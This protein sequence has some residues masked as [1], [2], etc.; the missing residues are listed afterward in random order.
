MLKR[1]LSSSR[2]Q[3][4]LDMTLSSTRGCLPEAVPAERRNV[5][6]RHALLRR[7]HGEFEEMRGLAVTP[8]QAAKL[9][10]LPGDVASRVLDQLAAASILH[11]RKDGLF[12]LR[13]EQV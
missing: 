12:A 4:L 13:A 11:C 6:A 2:T 1:K 10:G 7:I 8:E 9:F 3:A 5:A